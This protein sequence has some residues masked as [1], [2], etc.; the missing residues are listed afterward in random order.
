MRGGYWV[1]AI[2][3]TGWASAG[4][5]ASGYPPSTAML[6]A[7]ISAALLFWAYRTPE[8]ARD[9]GPHVRKLI[10]RWSL[11]EGAAIVIATHLLG[12]A[13]RGD[14]VFSTVALIIGLHFLPLAR[15]IPMRL[16]YLTGGGLILAGARGILLPASERPLAIGSAAAGVLWATAV[17][18]L[19]EVRRLAPA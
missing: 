14:A 9:A 12:R 13:H 6:P 16:Y 5:L 15:G 18:R 3:A 4:L 11:I 17:Y 19:L 10:A 1:V 8:T 2:F 7:I